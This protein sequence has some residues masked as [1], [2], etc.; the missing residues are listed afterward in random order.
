MSRLETQISE[1]I[2][3]YIDNELHSAVQD[4]LCYEDLASSL[5]LDEIIDH[6]D[7]DSKFDD[8]VRDWIE[9][10]FETIAEQYRETAR[11][12]VESMAAAHMQRWL[13]ENAHRFDPLHRRCWRWVTLVCKNNLNWRKKND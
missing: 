3:A 8:A 6:I 11:Y 7:L 13:L 1:A 12:V 2:T 10:N 5:D 9:K 4:N